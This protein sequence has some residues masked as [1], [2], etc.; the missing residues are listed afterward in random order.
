MFGSVEGDDDFHAYFIL[1]PHPRAKV[2]SAV[3]LRSSVAVGGSFRCVLWVR[4]PQLAEFRRLSRPRRPSAGTIA[5]LFLL[6]KRLA[7]VWLGWS[8]WFVAHRTNLR[9][10]A[11]GH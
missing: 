5:R 7:R 8:S 11:R 6:L 10:E 2:Q 4:H 9:A 1:H 3:S